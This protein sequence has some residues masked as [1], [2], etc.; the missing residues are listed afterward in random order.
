[1]HT[2]SHMSSFYTGVRRSAKKIFAAYRA[3]LKPRLLVLVALAAAVA[4][5]NS[6]APEPLN[7]LQSGALFGGF[8]TYKAGQLVSFL[9]Q[10]SV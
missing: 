1:M 9:A 2:K 10:K 5:Y 3:A 7:G 4:A 6:L 8:F